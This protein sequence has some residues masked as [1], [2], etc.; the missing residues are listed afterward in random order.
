MDGFYLV[1]Q[2]TIEDLMSLSN[3]ELTDMYRA[4]CN[5]NLIN[6]TEN[7]THKLIDV[8]ITSII[9][10]IGCNELISRNSD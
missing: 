3:K 5:V 6:D 9:Y 2:K 10:T 4:L 7:S 8:I 1:Y